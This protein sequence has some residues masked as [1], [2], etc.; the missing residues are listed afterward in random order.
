MAVQIEAQAAMMEAEDLRA[1]Y[2]SGTAMSVAD[3][4]PNRACFNPN[5]RPLT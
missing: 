3:G 4:R 2:G 1:V 5:P